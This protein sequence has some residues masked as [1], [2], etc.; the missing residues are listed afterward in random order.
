[1]AED[2]KV[3]DTLFNE[4]YI[5]QL[6]KLKEL[7]DHLLQTM[8]ALQIEDTNTNEVQKQQL[9]QLKTAE[10]A[11]KA[12]GSHDEATKSSKSESSAQDSHVNENEQRDTGEGS[13]ESSKELT[14]T[15]EEQEKVDKFLQP[16]TKNT[17]LKMRPTF[18]VKQYTTRRY[19]MKSIGMFNK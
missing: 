19:L 13:I 7:Q 18:K 11:S 4:K 1:M 12:E 5:Q 8:S 17:T 14:L 9:Y 16:M 15:T 2:S 10:I 3:R 6:A